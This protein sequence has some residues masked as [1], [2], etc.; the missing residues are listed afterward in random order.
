MLASV[1]KPMRDY[2]SFVL[3]PANRDL[4]DSHV[5]K[6]AESADDLYLFDLYPIVVDSERVIQDGQHRFSVCRQMMLPFYCIMSDDIDI[7]D[8]AEANE[9]TASYTTNDI[10]FVYAAMGVESYK[11]LT[12]YAQENPW[13]SIDCAIRWMNRDVSRTDLADGRFYAK[14]PGYARAVASVISDMSAAIG[15]SARTRS[16]VADVTKLPYKNVFAN[17]VLNPD[18]DHKRMMGRLANNLAGLKPCSTEEDA[19]A[20]INEVYNFN[21]PSNK[22][23]S[24]SKL[25]PR[26]VSNR[27]DR[28]FVPRVPDFPRQCRGI[29]Y[30]RE[31]EVFCSDNLDQFSVCPGAR[32]LLNYKLDRLVDFMGRRNLLRYFPIIVDQNLMVYDGQKRLAAARRLSLPIYYIVAHNI[33]MPMMIRSGVRTKS[34]GAQDYLKHFCALGRSEYLRLRDF[35]SNYQFLGLIMCIWMTSEQRWRY[36]MRHAYNAGSFRCAYM[37]RAS[38]AAKVIGSLTSQ[39][40]RVDEKVQRAMWYQGEHSTLDFDLLVDMLNTSPMSLYPFSTTEECIDRMQ[41]VYN[42]NVSPERQVTLIKSTD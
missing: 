7:D 25:S 38:R 8:V 18:Y 41:A 31:I 23:I 1:L 24:L 28:G 10:A 34:W 12:E 2:G 33:S 22:R 15:T 20:M 14:T 39:L 4:S 36:P 13:S 37:N 19:F 30:Q 16:L 42:S 3:D 26:Q 29:V 5:E 21:L 27:Y 17:L 35:W 11:C 32:P 9:N 40:L 6:I